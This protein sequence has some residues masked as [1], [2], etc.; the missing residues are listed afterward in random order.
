M[1]TLGPRSNDRCRQVVA[2]LRF[3][4]LLQGMMVAVDRWLLFG[5]G[6]VGLYFKV[7]PPPFYYSP[8]EY[9]RNKGL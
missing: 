1:N 3:Q 9:V 5:G 2:I 4:N 7:A 6:Q 8:S